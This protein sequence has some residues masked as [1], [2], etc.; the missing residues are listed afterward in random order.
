M[1]VE[2]IAYEADG[3]RLVGQFAVDDSRPGKRPGIL[4]CHEGNGLTE[5]TKKI[6]ARLATL[7]Y[8]AFAMDYYGDGKPLA[9][10]ADSG[11]RLAPWRTDPT[12]IRLRATAALEMLARR[13]E[14]IRR[15]WPASA[16]ASA[17]RR[18]SSS[19]AAEPTSR[20]S[21]ASIPVWPRHGPRKPGTSKARCWSIS[22]PTI[23][24]SRSSSAP[25]SRRK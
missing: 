12:G 19:A 14:S 1:H 10:P 8:A 3:A 17:A 18:Y 25:L 21:S 5:H 6:A 4:V 11:A 9:N 22:A 13:P 24:S 16:T 23:R 15:A 7:G 20:P 2:D